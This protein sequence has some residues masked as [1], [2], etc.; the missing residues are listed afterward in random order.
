MLAITTAPCGF[1]ADSVA[2]SVS[3]PSSAEPSAEVRPRRLHQ[4]PHFSPAGPG[5]QRS[6]K[7]LHLPEPQRALRAIKRGEKPPPQTRLFLT[8]L[9][10]AD[11]TTLRGGV[12]VNRRPVTRCRWNGSSDIRA[13]EGPRKGRLTATDSQMREGTHIDSAFRQ[14]V[15]RCRRQPRSGRNNR[16]HT[17][18]TFQTS[19]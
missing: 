14:P 15:G 16:A 2:G 7:R 9:M 5:G 1:S 6:L 11:V 17:V 12:R 4:P 3:L 13:P 18:G 19:G 10:S 8:R